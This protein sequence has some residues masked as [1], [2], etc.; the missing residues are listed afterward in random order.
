MG[1]AKVAAAVVMENVRA[2]AN[3]EIPLVSYEG[4]LVCSSICATKIV[5]LYLI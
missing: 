3:G 1:K 4:V 5:K 2:N